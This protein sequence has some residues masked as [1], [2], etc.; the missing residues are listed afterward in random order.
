MQTSLPLELTEKLIIIKHLVLITALLNNVLP[1]CIKMTSNSSSP[2]SFGLNQPHRPFSHPSRLCDKDFN[3]PYR[4]EDCG[5]SAVV[6]YTRPS[7]TPASNKSVR[8]S[9]R[10]LVTF[11]PLP[12]A[13]QSSSHFYDNNPTVK[14]DES[15]QADSATLTAFNLFKEDSS[16]DPAADDLRE[17]SS[18]HKEGYDD[19]LL[20]SKK[21]PSTIK[22][23]EACDNEIFPNFDVCQSWDKINTVRAGLK[24]P[25]SATLCRAP[26]SEGED[27]LMRPLSAPKR[28]IEDVNISSNLSGIL[29]SDDV[30]PV[31]SVK[32]RDINADAP[33]S[34]LEALVASTSPL[35]F[36]PHE[37]SMDSDCDDKYVEFAPQVSHNLINQN[38][39]RENDLNAINTNSVSSS[40]SMTSLDLNDPNFKCPDSHGSQKSVYSDLGLITDVLENNNA[41]ATTH[42]NEY[43]QAMRTYAAELC[44]VDCVILLEHCRPFNCDSLYM[45]Y[46]RDQYLCPILS[47]LN[48]GPPLNADFGRDAYTS[49]YS[50]H[51]Y[52]WR[53]PIQ[54]TT[55]VPDTPIIY[56]ILKRVATM[57]HE[58][59][60]ANDQLNP[61][62]ASPF[63]DRR[64]QTVALSDKLLQSDI[65]E[66]RI[67]GPLAAAFHAQTEAEL[68]AL[69]HKQLSKQTITNGHSNRMLENS[70]LPLT[71]TQTINHSPDNRC[72]VISNNR[73]SIQEQHLQQS[74]YS[75]DSTAYPAISNSSLVVATDGSC[76]NIP[77]TGANNSSQYTNGGLSPMAGPQFFA[78][79][80]PVGSYQRAS[81]NSAS[82]AP[83]QYPPSTTLSGY[84]FV[85]YA[86]VL[87][88]IMYDLLRGLHP[89]RIH[90][91]LD[92][93]DLIQLIKLRV[94]CMDPIQ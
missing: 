74:T 49:L 83:I 25:H 87:L 22:G 18:P 39:L 84:P 20:I 57:Q 63:Y 41:S 53:K 31:A 26:P 85:V 42:I 56:K 33:K 48:G 37:F 55:L 14:K 43:V 61:S 72:A 11:F 7:S 6:S 82:T 10:R 73:Y 28:L 54:T 19:S 35:M 3:S 45:K 29:A 52:C 16:L 77:G 21:I 40:K 44:P 51:G 94:V 36:F 24:R 62:E 75:I 5:D 89:W 90:C 1:L 50:L 78:S 68:S 76:R 47:N 69:E 46:F 93:L 59:R 23:N 86:D 13:S 79:A 38:L 92:I 15:P 27:P 65:P 9:S 2:L 91:Q 4:P 64:W 70:H 32:F 67:V 66:R 58:S 60:H 30:T 71:N 12:E 81:R 17:N 80:S 88:R 8:H 34:T